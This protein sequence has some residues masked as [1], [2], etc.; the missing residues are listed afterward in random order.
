MLGTFKG[1]WN[2]LQFSQKQQQAFLEDLAF[3]TNDGVPISQAVDT[4][5]NVSSDITE[6]VATDM[7]NA[8][9]AG[10]PVADGMENWFPTPIV[11]IIRAGES[12]GTLAAA[13][14][15]ASKALSQQ[16]NT[17]TLLINNLVYPLIVL[18]L[19]LFMVVFIKNS[20]LQSF[21]KIKPLTEW[22][23]AGLSI[24]HLAQF[25]QNWW[26]L[27]IIMLTATIYLIINL[28][29][30]FTGSV[31]NNIDDIPLIS[32]YRNTTAARFMQTLGLLISNGIV[33]KKALSIMQRNA[34][35][36]L[37]W[38]LMRM[39]YRLSG[40]MDNIGDVLD[41]NLIPEDDLVRLKVVAQGKGFASALTSLGDRSSEQ[42]QKK[43]TLTGKLLS[44]GFLILS[45]VV[46]ASLILGIYSVGMVIAT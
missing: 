7:S 12:S 2:K 27:I 26:W 17:L 20:V 3:L 42:N 5:Q 18:S 24:Y 35:P 15:S 43:I 10:K 25:L 1:K 22:P 16:R 40:G 4:I 36:Y 8:I 9:A 41:T 39:E 30:N 11:E 23:T 21:V 32:L 37:S 44:A 34:A 13:I 29:K 19:A 31:R 14:A 6:V 46:A 33:L 28:L 45:A 38:H